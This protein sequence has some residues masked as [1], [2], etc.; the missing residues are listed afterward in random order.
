MPQV[1]GCYGVAGGFDFMLIL[2]RMENQELQR[3]LE[4]IYSLDAVRKTETI[5]SLYREF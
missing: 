3:W 5:L 2:P 1:I 4:E